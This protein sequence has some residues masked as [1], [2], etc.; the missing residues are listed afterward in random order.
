MFE[1][2]SVKETLYGRLV[3]GIDALLITPEGEKVIE[4]FGETDGFYEWVKSLPD[5]LPEGRHVGR[6]A[7][8]EHGLKG[9]P[10]LRLKI[11]SQSYLMQKTR[12]GLLLEIP[13]LAEI[14]AYMAKKRDEGKHYEFVP[15]KLYF[16]AGDF[17]LTEWVRGSDW[18]N[19]SHSLHPKL[20]EPMRELRRDLMKTELDLNMA[21]VNFIYVGRNRK[22]KK[23]KFS[24]IDQLDE[25]MADKLK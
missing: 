7:S 1:D 23:P 18:N 9:V 3:E 20:F 6:I 15:Q 17:I 13:T 21:G 14:Q 10:D 11:A 19:I 25:R 5:K 24:V 22:T 8:E 12:Y 4:T 16:G 2:K